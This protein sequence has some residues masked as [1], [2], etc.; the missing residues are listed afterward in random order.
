MFNHL[1]PTDKLEI[2]T[3]LFDAKM[4]EMDDFRSKLEDEGIPVKKEIYRNQQQ[5]DCDDEEKNSASDA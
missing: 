2:M 1:A 4:D 3:I 5:G